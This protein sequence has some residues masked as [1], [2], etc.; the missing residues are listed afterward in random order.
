MGILQT[1]IKMMNLTSP[2]QT[3]QSQDLT[4]QRR[5]SS[6]HFA[7]NYRRGSS[8]MLQR[9]TKVRWATQTRR[10]GQSLRNIFTQ[11]DI[12]AGRTAKTPLSLLKKQNSKKEIEAKVERGKSQEGE[13]Q[14]EKGK[15]EPKER[16][17]LPSS[18]PLCKMQQII[19]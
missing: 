18:L 14:Q 13:D 5:V 7:N 16:K 17:N 10:L 8:A 2:S 1:A 15:C 6:A 3:S 9:C 11:S 12:I 19:G 4:S